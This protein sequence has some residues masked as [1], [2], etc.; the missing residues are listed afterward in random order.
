MD[1]VNVGI[2]MGKEI[3]DAWRNR[4]FILLSVIFA[5]L[6]LA[7]SLFGYSGLGNMGV[8]GFGRTTASILNLVLL[9]VPLMGLLLGA[10]SISSEREHG[11]L[12]ALLAQPVTPVEIIS[13]KF[14]GLAAAIS[15][16]LFFGFGLSGWVIGFY[17]GIADIS[18][19]LVLAALTVLLAVLTLGIGFCLSVFNK[20]STTATGVA[21]FVWF[22]LLFISDL[23]MMGTAIVMRFAPRVM[24]WLA[25]LNPVQV[26]RMAAIECIRGDLDILGGTGIY[27]AELFG[28]SLMGVL[29]I[30]LA[31]WVVL[32]FG[33]AVYS[34]RR[35]AL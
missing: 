14:L 3:R 6:A 1:I 26:F 16:T 20:K 34:F 7:F 25:M 4:W 8:A 12:S 21:I 32:P 2:I 23:G 18:N 31:L 30:L 27:A 28:D 13:G 22:L 11:T 33:L 35:R 29:G 9:I 15:G 19:Y 10:S 24:L 5:G 17:G